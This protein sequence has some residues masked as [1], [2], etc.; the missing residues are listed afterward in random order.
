M[1]HG[2]E[3]NYN[4]MISIYL[5]FISC[6]DITLSVHYWTYPFILIAVAQQRVPR[7]PGRD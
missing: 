5:F 4:E 2:D 1:A 7:V 3:A 6:C